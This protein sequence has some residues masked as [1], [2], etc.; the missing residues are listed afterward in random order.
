MFIFEG[1]LVKVTIKCNIEIQGLE[2]YVGQLDSIEI[3]EIRIST[4]SWSLSNNTVI[5]WQCSILN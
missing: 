3:H 2:R 1:K 5:L 4:L